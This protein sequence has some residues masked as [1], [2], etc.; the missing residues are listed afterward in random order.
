MHELLSRSAVAEIR[1]VRILFFSRQLIICF[2][3]RDFEVVKRAKAGVAKK[4]S[5]YLK[6][7]VSS[8]YKRR[9]ER[10]D[11]LVVAKERFRLLS[12]KRVVSYTVLL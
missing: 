11:V 7:F 9:D 4:F 2:K 5:V 1:I 3:Q 8:V 12:D 10:F 6:L